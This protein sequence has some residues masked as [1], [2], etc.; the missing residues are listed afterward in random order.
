MNQNNTTEGVIGRTKVP[1][2]EEPRRVGRP[3]IGDRAA[4]MEYANEILDYVAAHFDSDLIT[5]TNG[6]CNKEQLKEEG[7]KLN[8][9]ND[10][11]YALQLVSE[12]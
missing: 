4:F 11:Q 12:P 3:N 7:Q 9:Y 8:N 2:F 6:L 1:A 5:F 10:G